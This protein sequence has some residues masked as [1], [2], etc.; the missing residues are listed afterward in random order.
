MQLR[1]FFFTGESGEIPIWVCISFSFFTSTNHTGIHVGRLKNSA[2]GLKACFFPPQGGLQDIWAG[3]RKSLISV[4]KILR[5]PSHPSLVWVEKFRERKR[6]QNHFS[7]EVGWHHLNSEVF[8]D[9]GFLL[10]CV[11]VSDLQYWSQ[12]HRKYLK[13]CTTHHL[14]EGCF[15]NSP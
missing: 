7:N 13:V 8:K 2:N 12:K 4:L 11:T 14:G 1:S 15:T 5:A 3:E 9:Q 6:I 10:C